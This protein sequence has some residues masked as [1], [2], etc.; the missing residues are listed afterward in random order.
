MMGTARFD[1][2]SLD[3][4]FNSLLH[5]CLHSIYSITRVNPSQYDMM[6]DIQAAKRQEEPPRKLRCGK[7]ERRSGAN[8]AFISIVGR[9]EMEQ[10]RMNQTTPLRFFVIASW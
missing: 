3:I 10:P 1:R 2:V 7:H 9:Y 5:T 8:A 6:L 4:S